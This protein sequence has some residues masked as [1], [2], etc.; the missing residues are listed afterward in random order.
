ML[1]S[2]DTDK[3]RATHLTLPDIPEMP[4]C[5][6]RQRCILGRD[7]QIR[8]VELLLLLFRLGQA[9]LV[10]AEIIVYS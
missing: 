10:T 5:S 7:F 8:K 6:A 2:V 4:R 1:V 9:K 3:N